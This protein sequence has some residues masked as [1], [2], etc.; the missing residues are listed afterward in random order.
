M[1]KRPQTKLMRDDIQVL[2]KLTKAGFA[3]IVWTPVELG[4]ADPVDME[5]YLIQQGWDWLERYRSQLK[6]G[7]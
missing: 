4:D 1:S 5:A 2:N 3:V 7:E 6:G